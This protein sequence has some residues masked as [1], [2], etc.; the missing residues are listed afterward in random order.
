MLT[1]CYFAN[2][3]PA[4]LEI[5]RKE[6]GTDAMLVGSRQSPP[7]ARM[8][9]RLEV[10]FAYEAQTA[11]AAPKISE[12]DEI[13]LELSALR[14]AVGRAPAA[15]PRIS[16]VDRDISR[17]T[18]R[19]PGSEAANRLQNA[20]FDLDVA[21]EIASAAA[22]RP[23]SGDTAVCKELAS[24]IRTVPFDLQAGESK[25]D[26]KMVAFIGPPGRG[27]STTLV[28][29]A[30]RM[31]LGQ[32]IPVRIYSAGAHAIG[33]ADQMARYSAI[34]GVPFHSYESLDG[35]QLALNGD[36]WRGLTL[37]DTPG[38]SRRDT[39][40]IS[41]FARFFKARPTMER[42]LVLR[43]DARSAD[44]RSV[45]SRLA[46]LSP[47]HLLFTGLDEAANAA[48]VVDTAVRMQL[49]VCFLGTGTRVPEDL[50]QADALQL[51]KQ[52]FPD[53]PLRFA[54]AAA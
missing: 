28:K 48:V 46:A 4:A 51:A 49:P 54:A 18:G 47:T 30:V 29:V 19:D 23:E 37:I 44:I 20:G 14:K 33:A 24:R 13:R 26:S 16:D 39:Q 25:G 34:L 15:V 31:A 45:T 41:D 12:L 53:A 50:E 1:K 36:N 6:L 17:D 11:E 38:L 7:E 21:R 2:T 35:L 3:V 43:A 32:R 27:K 52:V 10:T 42:H 8:F 9:G 40:E 22:R 5:A